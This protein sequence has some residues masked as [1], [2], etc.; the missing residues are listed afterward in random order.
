M[1]SGLFRVWPQEVDRQTKKSLV[2]RQLADRVV[3]ARRVRLSL[4]HEA[5]ADVFEIETFRRHS[6]VRVRERGRD[7][8]RRR[9][10]ADRKIRSIGRRLRC[11]WLPPNME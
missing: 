2:F 9:E 7:R 4:F 11:L 10:N 1:L 5:Q 8:P 3:G 6:P